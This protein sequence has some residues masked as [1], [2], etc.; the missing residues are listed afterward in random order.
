MN[1]KKSTFEISDSSFTVEKD[2]QICYKTYKCI[3]K[4]GKEYL[5]QSDISVYLK[6]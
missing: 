1:N 2:I 3:F 5:E 6:N 4:I